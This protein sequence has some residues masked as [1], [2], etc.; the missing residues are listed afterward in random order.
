MGAFP[1]TRTQQVRINDQLDSTEVYD[2]DGEL[3]GFA[4][5][6]LPMGYRMLPAGTKPLTPTRCCR[7]CA[8]TDSAD[9]RYV[10]GEGLRYFGEQANGGRA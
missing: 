5:A 2:Q 8:W 3:D 1:I 6:V 4:L 10:P 7:S 9:V